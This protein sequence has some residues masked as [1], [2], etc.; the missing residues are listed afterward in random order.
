[1]KKQQG[2]EIKTLHLKTL[3]NIAYKSFLFREVDSNSLNQILID[4]NE[5][6][7]DIEGLID[8]LVKSDEYKIRNNNLD[9]VAEVKVKK[10]ENFRVSQIL[11]MLES[12]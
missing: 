2:N 5:G 7:Y 4:M 10:H 9:F 3:I 1:M 6:L 11:A 8:G 12:S